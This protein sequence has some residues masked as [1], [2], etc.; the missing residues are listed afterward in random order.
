M[1]KKLFRKPASELEPIQKPLN[2]TKDEQGAYHP[3]YARY[4]DV[5][6]LDQEALGNLY[7]RQ[8]TSFDK[9]IRQKLE[10]ARAA[11]EAGN[12]DEADKISEQ[13]MRAS[14]F[15]EKFDK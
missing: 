2:V 10:L 7:K 11:S 15:K 14:K 1:G 5:Q 9:L 4:S 6:E 3:E 13:I 12:F 8:D